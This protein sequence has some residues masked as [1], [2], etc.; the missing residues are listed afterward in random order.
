MILPHRLKHWVGINGSVFDWFHSDISNWSFTVSIG[1]SFYTFANISAGSSAGFSFSSTYF[2]GL[3]IGR[4]FQTRDN[5]SFFTAMQMIFSWTCFYNP[6]ITMIKRPTAK[7]L[8]VFSP[9][10]EHIKNQGVIFD[11]D[12]SLIGNQIL[13]QIQFLPTQNYLQN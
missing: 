3:S 7:M 4:A 5:F 9:T 6:Q 11:G 10:T 13:C 8:Y 1:S 2:H 12:L